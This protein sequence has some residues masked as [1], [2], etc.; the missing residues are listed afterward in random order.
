MMAKQ[1][2]EVTGSSG[3]QSVSDVGGWEAYSPERV[4]Q[5]RRAG[6]PV[7]IDFTAK[8]CLICQANKVILHSSEIQRAFREKGVVTMSADWTKKDAVITQQLEKLGRTG[9]PVYVLYPGNSQDLPFILPQTL[10][11]SVVQEYLSKLPEA[12]ETVY[13]D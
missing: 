6:T 4:E 1:H 12:S 8:W 5:L 9:V 11:A 7:F 10:T 2:S 13:A 3:A